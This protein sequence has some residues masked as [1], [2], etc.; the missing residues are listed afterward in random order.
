VEQVSA[1]NREYLVFPGKFDVGIV[2]VHEIMGLDEY[3]RSVAGQLAGA[4]YPVVAVDLFRG[5]RAATLQE[6][7]DMVG[8]LTHE[9]VLGAL[10]GGIR[11]LRER[12]RE[13]GVI[14]SIGFCMGGGY[15]LQGACDLDFGFC[16]DYY[17]M[18]PHTDDVRGLKGPIVLFLGSEDPRVTPW[19][20]ASF[21]P[22]ATRYKKRVDVHLYPGAG[23]AFHRPSWEGHNP[24][25][26]KDAWAKTMVFL[27]E[28]RMELNGIVS[29]GMWISMA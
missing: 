8:Q 27:S 12:L 22:D 29:C 9:E 5:R 4:G 7:F 14:G 2:L 6:G 18:I 15:A 20:Y 26:A 17:G 13:K 16:I 1:E 19:A 23:H 28:R 21:L 24:A 3:A 11:L 25:A 10:S